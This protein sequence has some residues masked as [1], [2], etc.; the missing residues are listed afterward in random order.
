MQSVTL[1]LAFSIFIEDQE[2]KKYGS[3]LKLNG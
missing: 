3:H 2:P 1:R